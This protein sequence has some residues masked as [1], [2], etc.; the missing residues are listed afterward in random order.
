MNNIDHVHSLLEHGKHKASKV[1]D[2]YI[3]KI[4]DVMGLD[5]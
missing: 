1:A 2:E 5:Y 4:R 3:K